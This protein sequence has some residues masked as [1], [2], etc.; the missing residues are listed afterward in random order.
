M[1]TQ[2]Q[3]A[4][5]YVKE[6][7]KCKHSFHYFCPK[8]ILLELTGGDRPFIPYRKQT[9]LIN[10][11]T[12]D[13]FVLVLKSRQIGISTIIK[14]YIVWLTVF[15]ENVAV[16][17]ISKDAPEATDFARDTMNMI[18]KL[19]RWMRPTFI[20]RT[21]RTFILDNGSKCYASPVNP[22]APE[23]TLRGKS[24]TFLIID[25]AAFIYHIDEAWTSMVPALST[26]QMHARQANVPY[27]TILLSTP[28]RAVGVGKWFFE[29]YSR[30]IS[31]ESDSFTPFVIHWS[32]IKELSSDPTWYDNICKLFDN[33]KRKIEQ[34]LELKFLSTAGSFFDE[35]TSIE[36]QANNRVPIEKFKIFNGECWTY[37]YPQ[38]GQHYLIGV[39]TAPE[40]GDDK[41]SI[42]VFDYETLEQ[43][44][45]YQGKCKV[46][47][48]IKVV[49]LACSRYPGTLVIESNSYGN[50]VVEQMY[51]SEYSSMVYKE[52]RGMKSSTIVPGLST[53][54]KT[55]PLM[56]DALYSI[57]TEFPKMIKSSR[58]ALEL[59][60]LVSKP[61]GKVEADKGCHDDLALAMALCMYVR[62]YDPPL[63]V[64]KAF[65][66][67]IAKEM[68]DIMS[69]NI[70]SPFDE[71]SNAA[72]IRNVKESG[73]A[74]F[75]DIMQLYSEIG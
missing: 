36:L 33:D 41:S 29:R 39:D 42:E 68:N 12:Q 14:A 69:T 70:T 66:H 48:F 27:G 49:T 22:N 3:K 8:Y 21:E 37:N 73:A 45:E 75:I 44:W 35:E 58:L 23:K 7:L 62:K 61:S 2:I 31:G 32:D 59:V 28:N 64:D 13:K 60:G 74:G 56:I 25:E 71:M 10:L 20:K 46:M 43:V 52:K 17:I 11:L 5:D 54:A 72:I 51:S 15:H 38:Y 18:D 47:D 34:E 63:L 6:F 50:Q 26:N 16:G 55:R 40:H 19:P 1:S 57:V 24:I 65:G 53:N 9:E 30:A 4:E 67:G